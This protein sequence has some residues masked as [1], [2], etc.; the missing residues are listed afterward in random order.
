MKNILLEIEY[1][2]TNYFGWQ[3]QKKKK[4]IQGELQKAL[5]KLFKKEIKIFYAGRTDR[6]VHAQSQMANFFIETS[7]PLKNILVALNS[8]L[9]QDIRIKKIKKV[10][11]DF[12]AHQAFSKVYRYIILNSS[13]PSVFL[14][15]YSWYVPEKLDI[16]KMEKIS[17]KLVG[18]RDFS[19]FAKEVTRYKTTYRN[20]KRISIR[21]RSKFIYIDLEADG[22][23]R[24]MVRNIVYFLV[25][26]G[27]RRIS[28]K[29]AE[30]ILNK[31]T[32]YS[33]K[34]APSSGLYLY[35]VNYERRQKIF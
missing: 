7:I 5:K 35:K 3:I 17:K 12:F 11:S 29:E 1:D 21:K 30:L 13:V 6:G 33:K 34:P 31:K 22:F 25:E 24:Q 26:V 28:L 2:G 9:P 8:F 23:L 27:R 32:S 14:R 16:S 18:F 20:L 4:T 10:P 19:I 15:H